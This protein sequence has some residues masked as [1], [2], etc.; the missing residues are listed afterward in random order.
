M[1]T[2]LVTV[3]GPQQRRDI[4]VPGDVAVNELLPLL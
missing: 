3:Q 4:E 2:L 1:Q